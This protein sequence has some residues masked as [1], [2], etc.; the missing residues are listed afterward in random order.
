M[1][2]SGLTSTLGIMK[3]ICEMRK[4]EMPDIS[5]CVNKECEKRQQCYRYRAIA[6]PYWQS[7][8]AFKPDEDGECDYFWS[9]DGLEEYL[10][11][12]SEEDE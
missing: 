8:A 11:D 7:F 6:H 4:C 2:V 5:L 9:V 3:S 10:E 1:I 12:M